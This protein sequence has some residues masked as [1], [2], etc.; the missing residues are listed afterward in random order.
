MQEDPA[1]DPIL[2][3][4]GLRARPE[5]VPVS[6][7]ALPSVKVFGLFVISGFN[8]VLTGAKFFLSG[9]L[10]HGYLPNLLET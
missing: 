9:H 1:G 7:E 2:P 4:Q 3:G 5:A 8:A 6:H 10:F